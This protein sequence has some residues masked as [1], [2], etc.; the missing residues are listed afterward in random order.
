[1]SMNGNDNDW[2]KRAS[3]LGWLLGPLT[4]VL[5]LA[6]LAALAQIAQAAWTVTNLHPPGATG[7]FAYDVDG[8]HQVGRAVVGGAGRASLWRGSAGSRVDLHP[9]G[10]ASSSVYRVGGGQQVGY[11]GHGGVSRPALWSGTTASWVELSTL[12]GAAHDTT[13]SQQVGWIFGGRPGQPRA[14]LWRGTAG[15][16][17]ELHPP[18]AVE[19]LAFAID[20]GRPVGVVGIGGRWRAA[21]WWR[22]AA[23]LWIDLHPP[24][25]NRSQAFDADGGQQVGEV[26]IGDQRRA[27]LWRGTAVSWVDLHPPGS[28]E[29]KANAT[30][31]GLQVGYVM[32]EGRMRPSLW[33]GTA[34]SWVDLS[35]YLPDF[36]GDGHA[37]GVWT[38]GSTTHVVGTAFN[39][40]TYRHEAL[41]W[42]W[43][44]ASIS[45][46]VALRSWTSPLTDQLIT[47]E[48]REPGSTTVLQRE[49]AGL[50]LN[51]DFS[52]GTA[53]P[54]GSYD[55]T[56]KGDRWLRG[57]LQNV[58]FTASGASGLLFD[59]LIPGDVQGDNVIDLADFLTLAA[60]YE[61]GPP[62]EMRADLNGDG[63]VDLADFLL[64]ANHYGT[65]G[66]P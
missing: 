7:S 54:P 63:A 42:T 30:F 58:T 43:R 11:V 55:V 50:S 19:S 48:V 5:A 29:S 1:M 15:S 46:N 33:S 44:P 56:A 60:N 61:V 41:L 57:K 8:V 51:G 39:H 13:G 24:G 23:D 18:G 22:A 66:A 53:L 17:V 6:H 49:V 12:G 64:L 37:T 52:F 45:G 65:V 59:E 32:H 9:M 21:L 36:W 10:A 20:G 35:L 31:G 40:N 2:R 47:F 25:A 4:R 14:S 3:T 28:R 34:A 62:T 26:W 27:S 38:D 16:R